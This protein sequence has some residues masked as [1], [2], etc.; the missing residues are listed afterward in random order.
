MCNVP[1]MK[2]TASKLAGH[3]CAR[4]MVFGSLV[5]SMLLQVIASSSHSSHFRIGSITQVR[6]EHATVSWHLGLVLIVFCGFTAIPLASA[7][8]SCLVGLIPASIRLGW[9]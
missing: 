3:S 6:R 4:A 7:Y 5:F 1:N 2:A 9:D 8:I